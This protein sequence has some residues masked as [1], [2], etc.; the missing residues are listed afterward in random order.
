M[1]ARDPVNAPQ[2]AALRQDVRLGQGEVRGERGGVDG[3]S[4]E[5]RERTR[6]C[7]PPQSAAV[8]S[9]VHRVLPGQVTDHRKRRPA[10][11]DDQVRAGPAMRRDL[12]RFRTRGLRCATELDERARDFLSDRR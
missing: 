10:A 3:R 8:A 4:V 9:P 11:G 2:E 7:R 1:A 12:S 5:S 6:G